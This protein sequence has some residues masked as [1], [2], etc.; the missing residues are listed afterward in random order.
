MIPGRSWI[1]PDQDHPKGTHPE[2]L[3]ISGVHLFEVSLEVST[4]PRPTTTIPYTQK[5]FP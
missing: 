3:L 2:Y 4:W 5:L 1:D